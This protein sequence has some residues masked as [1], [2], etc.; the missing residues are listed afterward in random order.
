MKT[1]II[2]ANCGKETMREGSHG[3]LD[4]CREKYGKLLCVICESRYDEEAG[5]IAKRD[6]TI[7]RQTSQGGGL[8]HYRFGDCITCAHFHVSF[9]KDNVFHNS[10]CDL[11]GELDKARDKLQQEWKGE[12]CRHYK[13][14]AQEKP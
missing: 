5:E 10:S 2:C 4:R 6:S 9:L 7:R 3:I 8:V 1:R 12:R 14:T 11:Y 13:T